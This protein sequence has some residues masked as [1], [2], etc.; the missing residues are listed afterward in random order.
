[1]NKTAKIIIGSAVTIT[2]IALLS[3]KKK[4]TTQHTNV[5]H[6]QIKPITKPVVT[7]KAPV[8]KEK[9]KGFLRFLSTALDVAGKVMSAKTGVKPDTSL[10]GEDADGVHSL[11]R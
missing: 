8:K 10:K 5:S 2:G 1:M 7:Y 4:K 3:K 6:T 11:Q 9:K